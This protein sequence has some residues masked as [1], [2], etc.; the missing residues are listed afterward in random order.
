MDSIVGKN[1]EKV[2]ILYC[3]EASSG[4]IAEYVKFHSQALVAAGFEV[5]LL[6][7]PEYPYS[8]LPG[9]TVRPE[10]PVTRKGGS[11]IS[12]TQRY[13]SDSRKI[14]SRITGFA[15]SERVDFV[16]LD[17]FREYLSPFWVGPLIRAHGQR[18]PF[19][20]V[21]HDPVRDFVVGPKWWH[22]YSIRRAYAF[23]DDVF[24][25]DIRRIDF[26][27][28][29]PAGIRIHQIPHGPYGLP[30]PART[31]AETRA[32]L[33]FTEKDRVFLSFGQIRD[34]KNLD[35]FLRAMTGLPDSVKLLVAGRGDSG[36]Q[37]SPDFYKGEADRLGISS[38]CRWKISYINEDEIAELFDASDCVLLTYSKAFVSASG[39]LNIA[40]ARRKPILAS[41]GEGPLET[42]LRKYPIG[43]WIENIDEESLMSAVTS[44]TNEA[45]NFKFSEYLEDHS[46]ERNAETVKQAIF[47][48]LDE[49]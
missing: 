26:G 24:A 12:R 47:R 43:K 30:E 32:S 6:C 5:T 19:G 16:L 10:L 49:S 29:Q 27:G 44:M 2:H 17:C 33:G 45:G 3:A 25:H 48:R 41:G 4:G 38:R 20:V 37:K 42:A 40:V 18:V 13:V 1:K 15:L 34:G 8:E 23:I 9:V 36:S 21:A 28:K 11:A 39:V 35:L 7:R 46:W 14:A 31:R 22:R